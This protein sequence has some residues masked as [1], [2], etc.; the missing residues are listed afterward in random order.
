VIDDISLSTTPLVSVIIPCHNYGRLL[1]DAIDSALVQTYTSVEVIVVDDG[2][3]D[4]TAA[5]ASSYSDRVLLVRQQ[6]GGP[7][8]A[9]NAGARA[10]RGD[11]VV[12]LDA[13]D[14]LAPTYIE[15]TL[16]TMRSAPRSVGFIYTSLRRFEGADTIIVAP[17]FNLHTL[18]RNNYIHVSALV[19]GSAAREIGYDERLRRGWEDWDFYLRL[20]AQGFTGQL[21]DR[22]LLHYRQH[23]AGGSIQDELSLTRRRKLY[24]SLAWRHRTLFRRRPLLFAGALVR[25]SLPDPVWIAI[26]AGRALFVRPRHVPRPRT[27]R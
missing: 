1:G 11:Y 20:C 7:G 17:P 4:E 21:C 16:A 9:R 22:P 18:L 3:T 23:S 14:S 24:R 6:N 15:D 19:L 10:S 13:D 12:F 2:S 5:V 27:G 26:R 8:S 25:G